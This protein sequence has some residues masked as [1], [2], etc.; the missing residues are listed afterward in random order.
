[1]RT[2][3]A[4]HFVNLKDHKFMS[5]RTLSDRPVILPL[6]LS[7][8]LLPSASALKLSAQTQQARTPSETTREFFKALYEKRFRE[9]LALSIYKPAIDALS[10]KEFDELKPDFEAMARG[11]DSVEVT[12]EQIS[13]ETATVFVKIKD[14]NGEMQVSKV[15][16]IRSGGMWIV[17]N[18]TDQQAVKKDGKDYFYNVR[19]QAHEADA[20]EMMVRIVKAQLVYNSQHEGTYADIPVLLKEGLLP[21][22]ITTSD[23][24]GY[25]Y[26]VTVGGD[27]KSYTAGAE[28]AEYGRTGRISY[29]LDATGLKGKDTGGKPYIPEKK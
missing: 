4:S 19:L 8:L 28:P 6:L 17:G 29:F 7:L 11:A 14:D 13:G 9:A 20:Q 3:R 25:R 10:A 22:D 1:L 18:E 15:D 21:P 12:G 27:K 5:H 26:H 16:L 23:S 2:G 24:T